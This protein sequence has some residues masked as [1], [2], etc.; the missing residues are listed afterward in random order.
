M[1]IY[2]N[3]WSC[4]RTFFVRSELFLGEAPLE[5]LVGGGV[6]WFLSFSCNH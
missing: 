2:M 5:M 1:I 4:G 6:P 3:V